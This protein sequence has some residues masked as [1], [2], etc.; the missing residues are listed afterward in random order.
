MLVPG[1]LCQNH[2]FDHFQEVLELKQKEMERN[3]GAVKTNK[4]GKS[5]TPNHCMLGMTWEHGGVRR[6]GKDVN[7]GLCLES[8]A[9]GGGIQ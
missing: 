5:S 7:G 3:M 9:A 2:E 6:E 4:E 8:M 1:C